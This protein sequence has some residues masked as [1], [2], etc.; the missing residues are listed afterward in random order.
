MRPAILIAKLATRAAWPMT[1]LDRGEE[2]LAPVV[3]CY[4]RVLPPSATNRRSPPYSVTPDQ[5]RRQLS[6]LAAEGFTSL[7]LQEFYEAATGVRELPSRCVLITFDDGY[8]DNHTIAWP[9]T[10]EFG[11]KLNLFICTGLL[12]GMSIEAFERVSAAERANRAEAPGLW[13]PLSWSQL[14]EMN[15]GGV[16]LG[17]HSHGHRNLGT[18]SSEE[19][20]ADAAIGI[21]LIAKHL[22]FRPRFFAFPFGHYGSHSSDARA[23]LQNQGLELFFTTEIGRTAP[24]NFQRTFARIVIH[25]EDDV[26]SFRRKLFGGYDWMGRVRRLN[27]SVRD[28]L[29]RRRVRRR[30]DDMFSI[31]NRG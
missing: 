8:N 26:H 18:M 22:G 2:R 23:A 27:Y 28:S 20:A 14:R 29:S 21:S 11:V 16:G 10:R 7:S 1:R 5:F 13:Q 12:A 30:S 31:V 9:I 4:H 17:F 25:P 3:L 19:I 24:G 6:V 15:A